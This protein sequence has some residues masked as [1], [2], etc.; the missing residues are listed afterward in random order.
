MTH[1]LQLETPV[2]PVTVTAS[3]DAV[4]GLC[5]GTELPEDSLLCREEDATPLLREA[6]AQLRE[7][8]AGTRRA[9]TLP[10]APAG[11]AFQQRVWKA[12]RTIPCGETRTYKQ[13]AEQIGRN[14]AYRAV[15]MANNRNP[16]AI[17]IPCH[18]VIGH[19]GR[20]TGYAGGLGIKERLLDLEKKR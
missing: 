8:F 7:Y 18:R 11:T 10:L 13:I 12:L 6:A 1:S 20:L 17:L 14:R 5:F 9:F 2:G 15:G 19:D 16:I 4:T 3:D